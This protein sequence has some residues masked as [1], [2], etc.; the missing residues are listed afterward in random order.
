VL[1]LL[2]ARW[3]LGLVSSEEVIEFAQVLLT[4]RPDSH[5]LAELAGLAPTQETGEV[6][7]LLRMAAVEV[8]RDAPD[9]ATA[10]RIVA[11]SIVSSITEGTMEPYLGARAIWRDVFGSAAEMDEFAVFAGL[12]S[13]WEDAPDQRPQYE[14]DIRR[15]ASEWPVR[16]RCTANLNCD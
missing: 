10:K 16:E 12:A 1:Q 15:V 11:R 14:D 2:A 5:A 3:R 4:G 13:G 6:G 8:G 9:E 7:S